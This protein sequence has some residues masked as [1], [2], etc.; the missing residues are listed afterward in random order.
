M[1]HSEI[2][3]IQNP[4]KLKCI[5]CFENH[6]NISNKLLNKICICEDSMIC[7]DCLK[8]FKVNQ[9]KKCPVCRRKLNINIAYYILSNISI[10]IKFNKLLITYIINILITNLVIYYIFYSDGKYIPNK[11]YDTITDLDSNNKLLI[12]N[13]ILLNKKFFFVINNLMI[14]ICYSLITQVCNYILYSYNTRRRLLIINYIFCVLLLINLLL[15]SI[16][17]IYSSI[18][19]LILYYK[20]NIVLYS[21]YG[22]IVF[23]I[24]VTKYLIKK[25]HF[26]KHN[27][28]KYNIEYNI[29][30]KIYYILEDNEEQNINTE[31]I[32]FINDISVV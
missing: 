16:L 17:I 11:L 20:F 8:E 28:M 29:L 15:L 23:T 21:L 13:I 25:F 32:N 1:E 27:Y 9:I 3:N 24:Y 2:Y 4:K 18:N 5:I 22:T 30:N 7:S 6:N 12:T 10:F 14:C 19:V 26:I 31:H